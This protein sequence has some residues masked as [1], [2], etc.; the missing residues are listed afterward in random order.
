[1]SALGTSLRIIP[2]GLQ[3]SAARLAEAGA[4]L[5]VVHENQ[6]DNLTEQAQALQHAQFLATATKQTSAMGAKLAAS[7]LEI[8]QRGEVLGQTGSTAIEKTLSNFDTVLAQ[9]RTIK[10]QISKVEGS[11]R[12]IGQ[13]TLAVKDL[14]DQSNMLALNAAIEAVR[15]GEHGRGFSVVAR[16]IRTLADQSIKATGRIRDIL[17]EVFQG[18]RKAVSLTDKGVQEVEQGLAEAKSSGQNLRQLSEIIHES[19]KAMK[20]IAIAVNQQ[21]EGFNGLFAAISQLSNGMDQTMRTLDDARAASD[22]LQ[23]VS[24]QV[25][26]AAQQYQQR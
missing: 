3:E 2:E 4:N 16:E 12:Q 23:S 14:A 5:T 15:S 25:N 1:V 10:D 8:A 22:A 9:V 11:A 17:D 19:A 7:V 13:I 6:R 20:R 21:D 26:R 18:V 24:E